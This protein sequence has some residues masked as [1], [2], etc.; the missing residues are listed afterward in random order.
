M[1]KRKPANIPKDWKLFPIGNGTSRWLP[2]WADKPLGFAIDPDAALRRCA[3]NRLPTSRK[4][5]VKTRLKS[6]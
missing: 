3:Y 4:K 6:R 5:S 1:P 2:D